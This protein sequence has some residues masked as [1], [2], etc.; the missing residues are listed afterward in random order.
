MSLAR[1]IVTAVISASC[2]FR[3]GDLR[4]CVAA[5]AEEEPED[6]PGLFCTAGT[7]GSSGWRAAVGDPGHPAPPV[8]SDS[9]SSA[10]ALLKVTERGDTAADI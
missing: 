2:I 1:K 9:W 5:P 3:N 7:A 10:A 8:V 4:T 6:L